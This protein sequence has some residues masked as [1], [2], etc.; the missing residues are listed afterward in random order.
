MVL[1]DVNVLIN[2]KMTGMPA[3]PQARAWLDALL[4][5]DETVGLPWAVL[6]AFVRIT[7]H[8]RAMTNPL[9][10]NGALDQVEEWLALPGV[11]VL[12]PTTEHARH[13][14]ELCRSAN[15]TGNLVSDAHLA[16]LAVEHDCDLASNDGDF[17]RFPSVRWVDPMGL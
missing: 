5:S 13:F 2:A 4:Q 17:A 14:A 12:H 8:V 15:V 10:L 1:V 3:H 16:A 11:V 7:T 6:V 9:S